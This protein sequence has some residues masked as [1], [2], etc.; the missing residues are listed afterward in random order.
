MKRLAAVAVAAS[1]AVAGNA[2]ALTIGSSGT[3][4]EMGGNTYHDSGAESVALTGMTGVDLSLLLERANFAEQNILGIYG[5]STSGPSITVGDRLEIFRGGNSPVTVTD[6]AFNQTTG[7]VTNTS[8]GQTAMVGSTF[9]F[10]ITT[11]ENFTFYTHQS[12]NPDGMDHFKIFDTRGS[13]TGASFVIGAEDLFGL[14]DADFDD[15]VAGVSGA[16]APVP[17]PGTMVLLGT[18]L[19]GLACYGRWRMRPRE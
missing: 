4:M 7:T 17:E 9:G 2:S 8:T 15:M 1:L 16:A 12:L 14:G 18:A 10:Y 5:F 6:L 13:A 3:Q 19:L 11:P